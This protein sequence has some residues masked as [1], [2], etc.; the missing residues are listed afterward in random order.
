MYSV[1]TPVKPMLALSLVFAIAIVS[2]KKK[3]NNN[4]TNYQQV[5]LVADT[6]GYVATRIDPK[7][8]NPWGIAI[9]PTGAF[10]I[11]ANHSGSTT[12]YDRTGAQLLPAVN[13]PSGG[14]LN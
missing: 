5:N 9:G 3:D 11:S 7:L 12:I 8:T 14:M 1:P 4:T 10:W 6:A 13:I 2:C